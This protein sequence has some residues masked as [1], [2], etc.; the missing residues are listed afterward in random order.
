MQICPNCGEEN[1]KGF[2]FCGMCGTALFGAQKHQTQQRKIVSVLF[3]DV[4]GSTSLGEQLDP[5]ALR[6]ALARYFQTVR[7][8]IESYGGS[9]EKFIGDAALAIF[10]ASSTQV[11]ALSA[12]RAGLGIT[13]AIT[14]LNIELDTSFGKSIQV[15]VGISTGEIV[16]T[17]SEGLTTGDP[18]NRATLFE[19][20]APP[21]E[22]L[23]DNT[24]FELVESCVQVKNNTP[25]MM[26]DKKTP[27]PAYQ[28]VSVKEPTGSGSIGD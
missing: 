28:L 17:T 9:V 8:V 23:F 12:V 18:L 11:S 4:V 19:A 22:V 21:G 1:P 15:R 25:L 3:C 13:N 26:R 27:V 7:G 24:T 5:E 16:G 14:Q 10:A 6:L 2:K 20:A